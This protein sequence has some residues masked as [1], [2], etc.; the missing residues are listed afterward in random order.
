MAVLGKEVKG[1]GAEGA[2]G[3]GL[4]EA[5]LADEEKKARVLANDERKKRTL[6][7]RSR[8]LLDMKKEMDN[9]QL[10]ATR[11]ANQWR[12]IMRLSKVESLR[13]DIEVLSQNHERDVD[14]NDAIIQ[15]L[16]RNLVDAE[17]Q[18]ATALR[19]HLQN[20]D[21]LVDLQDSRLLALENEFEGELS[22]IATEFNDEREQVQRQHAFE[23]K[24][25]LDIVAAVEAEE[26]ERE[27]EA[28]QEHEQT[29][30][31]IRNRGLEE[32][33]VLRIT[34]ESTIEELER[35]FE[36]AHLNY[37]QQTDQ[38]TQDFKFLTRKD[39]DLSKEIETKIHR[40][41]RL[42]NSLA[43]WR[44]K[45]NQNTRESEE[46]NG[47]LREEK[48][49]ISKHFG[50]LKTRMNKFRESQAKRLLDLTRSTSEARK[51]LKLKL[52]L[53]E[54]VLKL[55]ELARRNET[56]DERVLPF[57]ENS[58]PSSDKD[59]DADASASADADA[60]ADAGFEEERKAPDGCTDDERDE[61]EGREADKQDCNKKIQG[62][63]K[64]QQQSVTKKQ[65]QKQKQN[66]KKKNATEDPVAAEMLTLKAHA[67]GP[68]GKPLDEWNALDVFFKRFNK[69]LL[70]KLAVDKEKERLAAENR[71][72][73]AL[74][75]QY[76]DGVSVR[77][78]I[79]ESPNP[80]L[81][82]NGRINL[83]KLAA[84]R[85]GNNHSR[86]SVVEGNHMVATH[87]TR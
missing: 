27:A 64:G 59:L 9:K 3:G 57:Y 36:A 74:M 8:L 7:V 83:T 69:A 26:E 35:H 84:A 33:N 77:P 80:L 61:A 1:D 18:Y 81:V 73:K 37:L 50:A 28:R 5:D 65:T 15:M 6:A 76:L 60:D 53:A 87:R 38:R 82:V 71:A 40:I 46:R 32:I 16:D 63:G 31:E 2:A 4:S 14:R 29:R 85:R 24:Q 62:K 17:E 23:K 22:S 20:I 52:D 70:S 67:V 12:V 75:Q 41:E 47:A 10:N 11:V 39:Q 56:Q 66:T 49:Q 79:M 58:T 72:L 25:L 45:I 48:Q 19:S 54:R 13:K 34:L 44:A 43:H 55:A 51:T 86:P 78:E 21:R 42:Q 30:E 68:N